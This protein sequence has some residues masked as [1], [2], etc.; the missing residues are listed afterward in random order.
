MYSSFEMSALRFLNL[1]RCSKA[2]E[3]GQAAAGHGDP[4]D[5]GKGHE[6]AAAA[7]FLRTDAYFGRYMFMKPSWPLPSR[8]QSTPSRM[9]AF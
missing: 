8:K 6:G 5:H 3:G 2:G 9:H 1:A 4:P 7:H